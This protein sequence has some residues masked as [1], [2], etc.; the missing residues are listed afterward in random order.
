MHDLEGFTLVGTGDSKCRVEMSGDG[1]MEICGTKK[2]YIV[3]VGNVIWY[4]MYV[5]WQASMDIL[6]RCPRDIMRRKMLKGCTRTIYEH[7]S[8]DRCGCKR[9][10]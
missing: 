3:T 5:V 4:E 1:S 9:Q 2:E 7:D 6:L 8:E 10:R